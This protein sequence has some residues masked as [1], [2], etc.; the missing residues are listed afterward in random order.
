M[1]PPDSTQYLH[2]KMMRLHEKM[3]TLYKENMKKQDRAL[4]PPP[5]TYEKRLRQLE[6][7]KK[8]NYCEK[9]L[10]R[11]E[12]MKKKLNKAIKAGVRFEKTLREKHKDNEEMKRLRVRYT[13]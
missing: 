11:L 9:R 1:F 5:S 12:K 6:R 2:D 7:V 3:R 4:M 13:C 10:R 8:L